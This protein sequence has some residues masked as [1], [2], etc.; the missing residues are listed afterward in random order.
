[1]VGPET[2]VDA[3]TTGDYQVQD[4]QNNG[5][6]GDGTFNRNQASGINPLISPR[7]AAETIERVSSLLRDMGLAVSIEA[8]HGA[9]VL[10]D[11]FHRLSA[12]MVAALQFEEKKLLRRPR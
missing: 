9:H 12:V 7:N 1:M 5:E 8:T 2:R 4:G 11:N 10:T 6:P 3:T